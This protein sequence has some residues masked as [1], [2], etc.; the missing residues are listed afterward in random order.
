MREL[1]IQLQR[2][3]EP[4]RC[5]AHPIG[6]NLWTRLP[7]EGGVHLH[8]IE[9]LRIVMKLVETT[10]PIALCARRWIEQAVPLALAGRIAP[11]R[12]PDVNAHCTGDNRYI[13]DDQRNLLL[14]PG[15]VVI[16]GASVCVHSSNRVRSAVFLVRY[17]LRILRR[18]ETVARRGT[19]RSG[20]DGLPPC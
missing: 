12:C 15:R 9:M 14:D 13:A 2:E 4:R 8:R 6:G 3:R 5:A 16:R 20:T 11:A 18:T 7:I 19:H 10:G 17:P 1:L